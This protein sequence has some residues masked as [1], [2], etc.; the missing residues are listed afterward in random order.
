MAARSGKRARIRVA[1]SA[2]VSSTDEAFS[3][4]AGTTNQFRPTATGRRHWD[5]SS[6]RPIVSVGG[7]TS[8]GTFEVNYVQGII[9]FAT[10]PVGAV[11]ADIQYHTATYLGDGRQWEI[12]PEVDSLDDTSFSTTTDDVTWRTFKSGLSG[13]TV[14]IDQFLSAS[15]A[16]TFFD[17]VNTEDDLLV[18]LVADGSS[19]DRWEGWGRVESVS[20]S[21][22]IEELAMQG[23]TIRGDGLLAFTT[24]T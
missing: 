6:S 1:A 9:T 22:P 7:A 16:P 20:P 12:N 4:V 5:R 2:S 15:S 3:A 10:S 13:W 18:E 21:V 24:T 14:D 17:Q 11:T 8:T 19:G 23:V